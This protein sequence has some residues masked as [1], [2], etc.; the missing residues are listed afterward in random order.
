MK[1]TSQRPVRRLPRLAALCAVFA[2]TFVSGVDVAHAAPGGGKGKTR[3]TTEVS[4]ATLSA[5][6]T[7]GVG[8]SFVVSGS[9]FA[10]GGYWLKVETSTSMGYLSVNADSAGNFSTDF[11]LWTADTARFSLDA[12]SV[13]VVAS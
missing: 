2:L 11:V 7:V 10:S 6:A 3:P 8:Q 9:G 5:P 13:S 4:R 12:A 1:T